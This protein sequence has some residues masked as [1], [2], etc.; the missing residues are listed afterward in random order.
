MKKAAPQACE[1]PKVPGRTCKAKGRFVTEPPFLV[2]R[3]HLYNANVLCLPALGALDDV[4]LNGLAFLKRTETVALDGGVM[5][6]YVIAVC[7][8]Q[9]AETLGIVKPF[10]C[11][12]F[13]CLFLSKCNVPLNA[14]PICLR[15]EQYSQ[16]KQVDQIEVPRPFLVYHPILTATLKLSSLPFSAHSGQTPPAPVFPDFDPNPAK[17][18]VFPRS[19]KNSRTPLL[20]RYT[21]PNNKRLP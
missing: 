19:R 3:N 17:I 12:L 16:N 21:A 10:H 7:A 6:E 18:P 2:A 14:I 8:A 9:K 11:S 1:G 4:E 15:V 13:H 20:S 5:N